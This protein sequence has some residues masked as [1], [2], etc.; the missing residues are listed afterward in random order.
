MRAWDYLGKMALVMIIGTM[1]IDAFIT[2]ISQFAQALVVLL[3]FVGV[4]WIY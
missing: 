2:P 4:A 1:T 3:A